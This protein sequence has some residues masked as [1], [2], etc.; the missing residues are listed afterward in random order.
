MTATHNHYLA[1]LGE[2]FVAQQYA[3]EGYDITARNV[4]F[5]VGEIDI[6]ATSP[7]G[8]SSVH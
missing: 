3:N 7:Q 1:V 5:S 8:G 6:I 2:D 4:S